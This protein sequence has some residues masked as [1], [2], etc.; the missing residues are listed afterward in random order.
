M[1]TVTSF[2]R[3]NQHIVPLSPLGYGTGGMGT[4]GCVRKQHRL[5]RAER[6]STKGAALCPDP[7]EEEDGGWTELSWGYLCPFPSRMKQCPFFPAPWGCLKGWCFVDPFCQYTYCT[8]CP[9]LLHI[10]PRMSI[11]LSWCKWRLLEGGL[12]VKSL[13]GPGAEA[14]SGFLS[15]PGDQT[16]W[17]GSAMPYPSSL[18]FQLG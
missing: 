5:L 12:T 9:C 7:C 13:C 14:G 1:C 6:Q 10:L 18:S 2:G 3:G 4:W 11:S 15:P 8:R 17:Q 16:L